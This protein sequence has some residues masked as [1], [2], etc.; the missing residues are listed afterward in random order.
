MK[1]FGSV[2]RPAL[3][4]AAIA[5]GIGATPV[6]AAVDTSTVTSS[7]ISSL[8]GQTQLALMNSI[9]QL[10]AAQASGKPAYVANA[11]AVY[12][13]QFGQILGRISTELINAQARLSTRPNDAALQNEAAN[14]QHQYNTLLAAHLAAIAPAQAH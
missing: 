14:L 5:L 13:Q 7:A 3:G 11:Y 9:E 2:V 6:S 4:L 8:P 12:E 1:Q 10:Q